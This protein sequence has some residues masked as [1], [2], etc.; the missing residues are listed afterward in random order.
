MTLMQSY[1]KHLGGCIHHIISYYTCHHVCIRDILFHAHAY[2]TS[3]EITL[4]EFNEE[5]EEDQQE[6]PQAV[7]LGEEE[8]TL[9]DLPKCPDHQPTSFLKGKS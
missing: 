7:A 9:E 1:W 4:S 3:E 6:T 2:R 8:Q 5:V